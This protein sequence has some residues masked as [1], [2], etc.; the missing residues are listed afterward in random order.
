M[1]DINLYLLKRNCGTGMVVAAENDDEA[2][3]IACDSVRNY[4]EDED[5]PWPIKGYVVISFI[6]KADPGIKKGVILQGY[7]AD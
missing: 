1:S 2:F 4:K 5:V 6:R 3:K 7:F